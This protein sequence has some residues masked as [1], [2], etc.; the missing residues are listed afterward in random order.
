MDATLNESM[1]SVR[2]LKDFGV[3]ELRRYT[4]KD[5]QR[6]RF[7]R[8]FEAFFPGAIQQSGAIVAGEFFERKNPC[9]FTWIRGFRDMDDRAKANAALYYG[10]VWKEHR[11]L[12][13]GLMLDSDDVLLLRPLAPERGI[14]IFPAVDPVREEN[15]A[16][17]V[18]VAQIFP[19]RENGVDEFAR[20]A[21]T[22]FAAY[23]EIGA[24]EAA[25]LVTLDAANNFPQLPIRTDGPYLV[26]L[27]I[28]KDDEALES[29]FRPLAERSVQQLSATGL[30]QGTVELALLDPAP[31]SRLRWRE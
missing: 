26:W 3:I 7:A 24:R 1:Q 12:M 28:F 13:N 25:V 10:P 8:C 20:Q 4:I 14:A 17:G 6:E 2:H 30:L 15:G 9:G 22:A 29:R 21:E 5:G 31:G 18:V 19:I 16:R 27:G 23:R 11:T